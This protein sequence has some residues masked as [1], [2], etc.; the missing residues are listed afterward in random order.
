MQSDNL[1]VVACNRLFSFFHLSD[2]HYF[3]CARLLV[4]CNSGRDAELI[5][6]WSK[7]ESPL[8]FGFRGPIG[9]APP[10]PR[11]YGVGQDEFIV[12]RIN[13]CR[14]GRGRRGICPIYWLYR[15][16]AAKQE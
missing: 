10:Y 15:V 12:S 3:N 13:G 7:H 11:E 14:L 1:W 6:G 4:D 8:G 2:G 5:V 16:R 9:F